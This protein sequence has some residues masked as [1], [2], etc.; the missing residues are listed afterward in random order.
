[1]RLPRRVRS[2]ARSPAE[3]VL[4]MADPENIAPADELRFVTGRKLLGL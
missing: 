3:L 4:A 2:F 1:M